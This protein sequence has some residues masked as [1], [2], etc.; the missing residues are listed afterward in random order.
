[1][2]ITARFPSTCTVCG[3]RIAAGVLIDWERGVRG[4]KHAACAAPPVVVVPDVNVAEVARRERDAADAARA[5]ALYREATDRAANEALA[6]VAV[7]APVAATPVLGTVTLPAPVSEAAEFASLGFPR[8]EARRP[9][10]PRGVAVTAPARVAVSTR[11][12]VA[13]AAAEG[14]GALAGWAGLGEL[15]RAEILAA[16]AEA[17]LP[18]DWAP[19][20]KSAIAHAGGAVAAL[21]N[22]GY[23]SRRARTE[24]TRGTRRDWKARW[25]VAVADAA[26]AEVN[27]PVGRVVLSV[28]LR[29]G[30][31]LAIEGH[32]ALAER[33][34]GEYAALREAEIYAAGDVTAWLSRI[35][36]TRCGATRFGTGYYVP[37]AGRETANKLSAALK[38]RW[39]AGWIAPLLPVAT[40]DELKVGVAS[41]LA[42][43]VAGIK[44]SLEARR[45]TA[46]RENRTDARPGEAAALG[47]ELAD[48]H[49]RVAA[50]RL[51]CG[52]AV[53]APIVAEIAALRETLRKLT[54]DASLRFSLLEL[55]TET[56]LAAAAPV[57][58]GPSIAERAADVAA[59][60]R[61]APSEPPV[62]VAAPPPVCGKC[63]A[64]GTNAAGPGAHSPGCPNDKPAPV[65]PPVKRPPT[66]PPVGRTDADERFS[67]LEL[68]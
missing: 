61:R 24:T 5:E 19:V 21:N 63:S 47:R 43:D 3:T 28:E 4:A 54:D 10:P 34:R 51:L 50:Y 22:R 39:G 56:E 38:K 33:V 1:M 52:D 42:D 16:L 35:L 32:A 55:F 15:R 65:A 46:K 12:I 62:A 9:T 2:L 40:S 53:V 60:R 26:A 66:E 31:D 25:V 8:V 48:I 36:S 6:R 20:A 18:A 41:G 13:G 7:A 14:Y 59:E 30:D 29:D 27:E 58:E 64:V 23:I 45:E 67:L 11:E 37:A 49:E 68:D 17:D 44:R 57:A